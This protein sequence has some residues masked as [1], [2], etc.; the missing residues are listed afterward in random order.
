MNPQ[1]VWNVSRTTPGCYIFLLDQSQ[2]MDDPIGGT[3]V[4][5]KVALANAVNYYLN[6][7]IAQCEK[8]DP[9]PW[10][11][12]D[13]ALIG[14]TTD[15]NGNPEIGPAFQGG[16]A[17]NEGIGQDLVSSVELAEARWAPPR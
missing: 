5:K 14:Y 13:V 7:L 12:Y 3:T 4:A 17:P 15:E 11:Y 10:H 6:E 1:D 16:L 9:Q 2:S 8:G